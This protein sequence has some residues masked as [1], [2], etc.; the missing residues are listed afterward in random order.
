MNQTL[1]IA[2]IA[3]AVAGIGVVIARQQSKDAK[4]A[5][6]CCAM[7]GA[8]AALQPNQTPIAV[9][10]SGTSP[11]ITAS[12]KLPRLLELGSVKCIPCKLMAPILEALKKEYEARLNVE[13]IDVIQNPELGE[14][15]RIQMIPTQIFYD[16]SGKELFRHTG[17]FGKEDILAKWKELGVDLNGKTT[18]AGIL[19]ETPVIP[20]TRQRNGVCFMC[21]GDIT[22]KTRLIVKGKTDQLVLCSPHCYFIYLS[23]LVNPDLKAEKSKV[24]V[25]DWTEG[26]LIPAT[27]AVY[28]C[29]M[30]AKGHQTIKAFANRQTADLEQKPAAGQIVDWDTLQNREFQ[31]RCGFCDRVVYI[32]DAAQVAVAVKRSCCAGSPPLQACCVMCALGVAA[33][34]QTDIDVEAPD[35]LTSEPVQ[36]SIRGGQVASMTPPTIVAWAGQKKG[37]DGKMVSAGCFKQ[38]FFANEANLQKWLETRPAMTG[39]QV[40]IAQALADKM[41]LSPEQITKACKLG[42][43]R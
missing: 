10:V 11:H 1:K 16:S 42:E 12:Q 38:A 19:R 13:F 34:Y 32:Q 27:T 14:K 24:S 39:R 20:D 21:D 3:L 29:G 26:K 9:T 23:S 40:T 15:Y 36:V 37:P 17:F 31:V 6:G 7:A 33:R 25:T 18:S 2:L 43:C 30:D 22:P 28:L 35:A 5:A 41:N 8:L 4:P